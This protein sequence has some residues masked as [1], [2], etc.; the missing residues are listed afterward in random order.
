MK[1]SVTNIDTTQVAKRYDHKGLLVALSI[2]GIL[3]CKWIVP[4]SIRRI[5]TISVFNMPFFI[6]NL[7]LIPIL[8]YAPKRSLSG[9]K[10]ASIFLTLQI[11]FSFIGV[12][13]NP[14]DSR[15]AHILVG[16]YYFYA[17][18]LAINIRVTQ[19]QQYLLSKFLFLIFLAL[20]FEI[21]LYSTGI[22][23]WHNDITSQLTEINGVV[24]LGSTIGASTFGAQIMF[25]LGCLLYYYNE[26]TPKGYLILGITFVVLLMQMSRGALLAFSLVLILYFLS[27]FGRNKSSI[28]KYFI[29]LIVLIALVSYT[30]L[31]DLILLR[32]EGLSDDISSGRTYLIAETIAMVSSN[33]AELFG[34]G[35]SNVFETFEELEWFNYECFFKAAPHNCWVLTYAEQGIVGFTLMLL[36]WLNVLRRVRNTGWIFYLTLAIPLVLFNTEAVTIIEE[37]SIFLVALII[38]IA[39]DK[40]R[41][42]QNNNARL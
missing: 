35:F 5:L 29:F 18:L 38:T 37:A 7:L 8:I 21:F 32:E 40:A 16:D 2:A 31:L 6:P 11:I 36:F 24:R 17:M 19:R 26:D 9:I 30:G 33:N 10:V 34:L 14:Y 23:V 3:F 12:F 15:L 20:S 25:M 42:I 28:F 1:Y 39:L 41:I 22:L 4:Q 13:S 27:K